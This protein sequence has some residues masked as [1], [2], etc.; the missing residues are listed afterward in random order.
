MSSDWQ[1]ALVQ[2]SDSGHTLEQVLGSV[3]YRKIQRL[4][5]EAEDS[6]RAADLGCSPLERALAEHSFECHT[7]RA[8]ALMDEIA[9]T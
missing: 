2:F 8:L 4:L 6:R 9:A 5:A 7:E 1:D 3:Y